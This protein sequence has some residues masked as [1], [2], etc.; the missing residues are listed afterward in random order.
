M[1]ILAE[2]YVSIAANKNVPVNCLACKQ[3]ARI[4]SL[5][6]ISHF[7]TT[8][9]PRTSECCTQCFLFLSPHYNP[10]RWRR[11]KD[12]DWLKVTQKASCLNRYFNLDLQGSVRLPNHYTILNLNLVNCFSDH[13]SP[14]PIIN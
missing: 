3:W 9:S 4:Y 14:P 2:S 8:L 1:A 12:S 11:L 13:V 5:F 10:V 6:I 7:Y